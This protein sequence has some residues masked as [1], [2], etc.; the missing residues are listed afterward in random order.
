MKTYCVK[1]KKNTEC[2]SSSEKYEKAKN[3]RLMLKCRCASCGITKC[4]FVRSDQV[5]GFGFGEIIT[6]M[7]WELGKF[8]VKNAIK[9]DITKR[10][11]TNYMKNKADK[12]ITQGVDQTLD[13][14]ASKIHTI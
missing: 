2:V 1:E 4:R 3:G 12:M 14:L 5:G 7:G 13:S 8:G 9:S 11:A 6:K 10:I